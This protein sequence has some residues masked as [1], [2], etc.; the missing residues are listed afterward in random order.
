VTQPEITVVKR[1]VTTKRT[2]VAGKWIFIEDVRVEEKQC[3]KGLSGGAET[4]GSSTGK[5]E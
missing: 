2:V 3:K 5:S 4:S 1:T